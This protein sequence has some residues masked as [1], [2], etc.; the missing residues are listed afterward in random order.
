MFHADFNVLKLSNT[1]N[2]HEKDL[3][4]LTDIFPTGWGGVAQSGFKPGET[5]VIFGPGPVGVNG[6]LQC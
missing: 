6:C 1:D 4:L 5:I 3:V 2:L